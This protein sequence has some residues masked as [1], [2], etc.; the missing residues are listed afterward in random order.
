MKLT[1]YIGVYIAH[2]WLPNAL[3]FAGSS[4]VGEL[5]IHGV[6]LLHKTAYPYNYGNLSLV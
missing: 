4:Q 3:E 6:K 1:L 5:P 2:T